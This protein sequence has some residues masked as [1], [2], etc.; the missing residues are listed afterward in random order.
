MMA[1]KRVGDVVEPGE[2]LLLTSGSYSDYCVLGVYRVKE[3][4]TIP[5]CPHP[6]GR[7]GE[8]I[9]DQGRITAN[10]QWVD[11]IAVTELWSGT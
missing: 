2:V 8:L 3:R 10:P 11:E 5:G 7:P 4:F 1:Q 6:W 9:V